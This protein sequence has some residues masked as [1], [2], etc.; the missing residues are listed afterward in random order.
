MSAG[1][2]LWLRHVQTLTKS[3]CHCFPERTCMEN[4]Q[5]R[6]IPRVK[7]NK[8]KKPKILDWCELD[9][10]L[11]S[12]PPKR[13]GRGGGE[14]WT[15]KHKNC[16][17]WQEMEHWLNAYGIK[18]VR[19]GERGPWKRAWRLFNIQNPSPDLTPLSINTVG[20]HINTAITAFL[21][22]HIGANSMKSTKILFHMKNESEKMSPTSVLL[23]WLLQFSQL[24]NAQIQ[25]S[26]HL[27]WPAGYRV[28]VL[29]THWKH[30]TI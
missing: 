16:K 8:N 15:Q 17:T 25:D 10:W 6:P 4:L 26:P 13:W 11:F 30:L 18:E 9:W 23:T 27:Y 14:M 7:N 19:V 12:H 5:R 28:F 2:K 3:K 20:A 24:L 22:P 29:Q 1:G 21:T